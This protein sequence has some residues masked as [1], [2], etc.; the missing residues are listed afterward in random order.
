MVD[1]VHGCVSHVVR[2]VVVE[3]K[4][5]IEVVTILNLTVEETIVLV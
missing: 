2:H 4:D 1:G 5:V 3:Y